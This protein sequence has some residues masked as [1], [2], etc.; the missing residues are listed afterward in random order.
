MKRCRSCAAPI[1]FGVTTKNRRMP[2]DAAPSESGT[3]AIEDGYVR[4]GQAPPKWPRYTS[5]F[6]TCPSAKL[7]RRAGEVRP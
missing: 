2:L 7:H 6:E 1:F 5:H 3:I 4:T